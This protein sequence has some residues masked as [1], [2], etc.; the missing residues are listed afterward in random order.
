[1]EG[2]SFVNHP[3]VPSAEQDTPAVV[4]IFNEHEKSIIEAAKLFED[5]RARGE[6]APRNV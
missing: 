2:S 1:M 5:R 3:N 4:H 6:D